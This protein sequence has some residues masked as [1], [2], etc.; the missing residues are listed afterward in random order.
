M[1]QSGWMFWLIWTFNL[2]AYGQMGI[3]LKKSFKGRNLYRPGLNIG[4][5]QIK[6]SAKL[7]YF[8]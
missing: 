1:V 8:E 2:S 5:F 4:P 7:S 3:F 6:K